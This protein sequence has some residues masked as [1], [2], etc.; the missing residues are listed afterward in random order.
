MNDRAMALIAIATYVLGAMVGIVWRSW[1]LWRRTGSTGFEGVSGR[2]GSAEWFGGIGV[3]LEVVL[4]FAAPVLQLAGIV[5]PL[6]FLRRAWIQ[7]G[8]S[9]S[10]SRALRSP[11]MHNSPWARRGGSV[12]TTARRRR[13]CVAACSGSSAIRSS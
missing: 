2:V 8:A 5:E 11:C 3:V 1:W 4:T 12:S 6:P 9:S 7:W 13:W 10:P